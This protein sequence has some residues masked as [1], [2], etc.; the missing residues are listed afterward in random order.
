MDWRLYW[1]K[2]VPFVYKE[3]EQILQKTIVDVK[4][5]LNIDFVVTFFGYNKVYKF[6]DFSL[7]YLS[8]T[9]YSQHLDGICD[10]NFNSNELY[11]ICPIILRYGLCVEKDDEKEYEEII[12]LFLKNLNFFNQQKNKHIFFLPGDGSNI[13]DCM[14]DSIVFTVSPS[15]KTNALPLYYTSPTICNKTT[16]ITTCP[17]DVSFQ[18]SLM[19]H[20]IRPKSINELY[21]I[22]NYSTFIEG[23]FE[24]MEFLH[25]K[26][27]LRLTYKK[28]I[29]R[30]KFVLCP[31]GRGS[32]SIRFYEALNF[33]KIPILISDDVKLPLTSK[34]NYSEFSI[35]IPEKDVSK[36]ENYID[37]FLKT[38]DIKTASKKARE[39]SVKWFSMNSIS[40]FVNESIKENSMKNIEQKQLFV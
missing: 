26:E 11:V 1:G 19:T 5:K 28:S 10:M 21:K 8:P 37:E 29:E 2:V 33:G 36:I 13:Y 40:D 39:T 23:N 15:L 31:R 3:H 6:K 9:S 22:K 24:F 38:H 16:D 34:I 7:S 27:H 17:I 32:N 12:K 25:N 20:S 18:G 30:C 35:K 14:K 4:K